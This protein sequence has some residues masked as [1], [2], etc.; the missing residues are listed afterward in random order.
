MGNTPGIPSRVPA[1]DPGSTL[2]HDAPFEGLN[3]GGTF[4]GRATTPE[5]AFAPNREA[6]RQAALRLEANPRLSFRSL[7]SPSVSLDFGAAARAR[8]F[9][10]I[11]IETR[12]QDAE[13]LATALENFQ[14]SGALPENRNY[15]R[16]LAQA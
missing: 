10:S 16:T 4:S 6:W 12:P 9:F 5:S 1:R 13:T 14:N 15:L 11:P 2:F 7:L 3:F 8:V